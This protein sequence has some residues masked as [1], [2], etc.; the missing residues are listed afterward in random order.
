MAT[1][2]DVRRPMPTSNKF[3]S[4][5]RP[6]QQKK[7]VSKQPRG[8]KIKTGKGPLD[9]VHQYE[10]S[11][12]GVGTRKFSASTSPLFPLTDEMQR[13]KQQRTCFRRLV[14]GL[15]ILIVSVTLITVTG[16]VLYIV[17]FSGDEKLDSEKLVE[18]EY[19]PPENMIFRGSFRLD[20]VRGQ[21]ARFTAAYEDPTSFEYRWLARETQN[22]IDDIFKASTLADRY[23]LT[24]VIGFREGSIVVDFRTAFR[25]AQRHETSDGSI[26]ITRDSV[27]QA[28]HTAMTAGLSS[29][30]V[31][32]ILRDVVAASL[33]LVA[34]QDYS[35]E[36]ANTAASGMS[37]VPNALPDTLPGFVTTN[38]M[39]TLGTATSALKPHQEPAVFNGEFSLQMDFVAGYDDTESEQFKV[40][41]SQIEQS[42]DAVYRVSD[43]AERYNSTQVTG[44][45]KGS[46]VAEFEITFNPVEA[47][48]AA[49]H[50]SVGIDSDTVSAVLVSAIESSQ[51]GPPETSILSMVDKESLNLIEEVALP[52]VSTTSTSSSTAGTMADLTDTLVVEDPQLTV[53]PSAVM[54]EVPVTDGGLLPPLQF[55]PDAC[56]RV[57]TTCPDGSCIFYFDI[58]D[59]FIDCPNGWDEQDCS[60]LPSSAVTTEM[61]VTDAGPQ[62]PLVPVFCLRSQM[63]CPDGTCI[64]ILQR[65][66]GT[67]DCS[68]GWDEE[69]CF[70]VPPPAVTTDMTVTDSGLLPQVPLVPGTGVLPQGPF[71]PVFCTRSQITCPDGT[72]I[73]FSQQCDGTIDCSNG[74]DEE[75][76]FDDCQTDEFA[77]PD[78]SCIPIDWV[79]D[80]FADCH[81]FSDEQ[82]CVCPE[83]HFSCSNGYCISPEFLCDADDDCGDG[84][85]EENCACVVTC[86]NGWCVAANLVCD[87]IYDCENGEDE[88]G[89]SS[90]SSFFCDPDLLCPNGH[91]L[92]PSEVCDGHID[93]P[94]GWDEEGCFDYIVPRNPFMRLGKRCDSVP[95]VCQNFTSY[96]EATFPNSVAET[97]SEASLLLDLLFLHEGCHQQSLTFICSVFSRSV[98]RNSLQRQCL[99]VFVIRCAR[100]YNKDVATL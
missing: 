18:D 98:N 82:N 38:S 11:E 94:D 77:C 76:C 41:A 62:K 37:T 88:D 91:C 50:G 14:I 48:S 60:N 1:P 22:A 42:I 46:V 65:C 47:D 8:N 80:F 85:D 79:C 13:K 68:N 89:C 34:A 28:L 15:I 17:V 71:L 45:R 4:L 55:V 32:S 95:P 73:T 40:L 16:V 6:H 69:D 97:Y 63:T 7:S 35:A 24:E 51:T 81:D 83:S 78:G 27:Y 56:P 70:V 64:N 43:M 72:C 84:Q 87:G 21:D 61:T 96:D 12:G 10:T 30:P 19:Q 36:H 29:Q 67:I 2:R 75:D 90:E 5:E 93:C 52:T 92:Y 66:D 54:T 100:V 49:D 74:W 86:E 20:S 57:L 59:G 53:P 9:V 99:H 3:P 58:C 25:G 39:S 31:N 23:N 33:V 26:E 44:F